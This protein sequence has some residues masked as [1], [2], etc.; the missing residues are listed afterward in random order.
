MVGFGIG[1]LIAAVI[2]FT[3]KSIGLTACLRKSLLDWLTQEDDFQGTMRRIK[4]DI[5]YLDRYDSERRKQT[6]EHR[7]ARNKLKEELEKRIE[8]FES[9]PVIVESNNVIE[10]AKAKQ[11]YKQAKQ[12]YKRAKEQVVK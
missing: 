11:K 4:Q 2:L 9:L 5:K 7:E 1:A 8:H 10:L 12:K 3:L 6:R